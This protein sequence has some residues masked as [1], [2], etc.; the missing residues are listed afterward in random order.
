MSCVQ[1]LG[2]VSSYGEQVP[3]CDKTGAI[4]LQT[5]AIVRRVGAIQWR[6]RAILSFCQVNWLGMLYKNK[7]SNLTAVTVECGMFCCYDNQAVADV[8]V[9]F[10]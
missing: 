9:K 4:L 1:R 10:V 6:T 5:C 8:H 2:Q 7:E 3:L